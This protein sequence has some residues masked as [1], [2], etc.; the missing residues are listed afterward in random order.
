MA[1]GERRL[2]APGRD[3][4]AVVRDLEHEIVVFA[5]H[6]D[7][8][9]TRPSVRGDVRHQLA[10][11]GQQQRRTVLRRLHR[12]LDARGEPALERLMPDDRLDRCAQRF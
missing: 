11:H 1:L 2:Q 10:Y 6:D 7:A 4:G 9:G 5:A 3:P 8:H 12:E